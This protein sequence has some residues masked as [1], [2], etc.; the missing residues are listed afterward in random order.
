MVTLSK[1]I[2]DKYRLFCREEDYTVL[3]DNIW[4]LLLMREFGCRKVT[5]TI[6]VAG[7]KTRVRAYAGVKL[8]N[9]EDSDDYLIDRRYYHASK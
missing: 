4:S 8:K 2:V 6:D 1:D 5:R 3:P 9:P 7:E